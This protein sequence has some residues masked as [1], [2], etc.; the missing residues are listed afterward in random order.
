M[1]LKCP[2]KINLFL[3]V[4]GRRPDGYHDLLTLFC[5]VGIY[6]WVRLE[7]GPAGISVSCRHPDVPETMAN[8]A[9]KAASLFY[10]MLAG[11]NRTATPSLKITID[12]HIPVGAGL[13]GGSSNAA[14]VLMG[15]NRMHGLPFSD[16][17]LMAAGCSLG[18]DVP[19]FIYKKPAVARGIGDELTAYKGLAPYWVVLVNPGIPV[20]TGEV[21]KNL[22]LGLTKCEQ[23]L[24]CLLFEKDAFR[25]DQHMCNDLEPVTESLCGQ[26]LLIKEDLYALGALGALMSGSGA[27]VFGLFDTEGSARK[28]HERL[29]ES[30]N[31][32]VFIT[33]LLV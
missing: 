14:S 13:G 15:L 22:N 12:K 31:N 2:A 33:Q 11:V 6:D 26:I 16:Q 7:K 10:Q 19:F 18:A 4:T 32:H 8:I 27:T 28:A 9:H 30:K 24:N 21:Y 23:K 1:E 17:A 5:R 29:C 3:A 25:V 20:S